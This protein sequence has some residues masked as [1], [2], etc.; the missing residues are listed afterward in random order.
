MSIVV[1]GQTIAEIYVGSTK[2]GEAWAW[3]GSSWDQLFSSVVINELLDQRAT[4][5]SNTTV[6]STRVLVTDWAADEAFPGTWVSGGKF[7]FGGAGIVRLTLDCQIS[8]FNAG[9]IFYLM[10]NGVEIGTA[11]IQY[12]SE[13]GTKYIDVYTS[14]EADDE[15]WVEA[16]WAWGWDGVISTATSL[17]ADTTDLFT[18][19]YSD[20]FDAQSNGD[21]A[22]SGNGW[23][24]ISSLSE[25]QV[26]DA[27]GGG[28]A[29]RGEFAT[30]S[31]RPNCRSVTETDPSGD[32]VGTY[33]KATVLSIG[34]RAGV[35]LV[36]GVI[37][38]FTSPTTLEIGTLTG[39]AG[40]YTPTVLETFTV[41]A[42][43]L[44]VELL[45][46]STTATNVDVYIDDVF[47]G[48]ATHSETGPTA[49]VL[50]SSTTDALD[51]FECGTFTVLA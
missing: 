23:D 41:P 18:P 45:L 15:I 4:I 39:S 42:V 43:S 25:P 51:D 9:V 1:D 36:D 21:L 20:N 17:M 38:Y 31:S 27:A 32:Y 5:A 8:G 13:N 3:N 14:V 24:Y 28:K 47:I 2:I 19:V 40:G 12:E 16:K 49:G 6:Q 48:S 50:V 35:W 22:Q 11:T 33:A 34:E 26:Y 37:A 29:I 10:K 7:T 46:L 30:P 44:P